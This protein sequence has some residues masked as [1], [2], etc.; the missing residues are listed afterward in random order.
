[1]KGITYI[2]GSI[3]S[4]YA[5][6]NQ[7]DDVVYDSNCTVEFCDMPE[8]DAICN[9]NKYHIKIEGDTVSFNMP[10]MLE[11]FRYHLEIQSDTLI[12]VKTNANRL[13]LYEVLEKQ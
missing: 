3:A 7:P 12:A 2:F 8:C 1:M 10:E 9:T 11:G 5:T 13:T 4:T 6:Y